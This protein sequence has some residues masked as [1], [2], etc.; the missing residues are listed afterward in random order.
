MSFHTVIIRGRAGSEPT[1]KY[2]PDGKAV[3]TVSV[4]VDDGY[5]D[6]KSTIW[7]RV[8]AWEK[9]AEVLNNYLVKGQELLV[10]GKLQ[11]DKETG[12]PRIFTRKDGT[13]GSS[14]ELTAYSIDLGAKPKGQ[15][16]QAGPDVGDGDNMPF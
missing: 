10:E 3:A 1:L 7:V 15:F 14:F 4:A 13:T 2:T 12:G 16:E 8:T 5:G 9:L 6:K 11:Y